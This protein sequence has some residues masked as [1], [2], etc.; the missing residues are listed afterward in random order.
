M[1]NKIEDRKKLYIP[2]RIKVEN[3][4]LKGFSG[5]SLKWFIVSGIIAS[6]ICFIIG[7]ITKELSYGILLWIFTLGVL[8][9]AFH[10]NELNMN[11]V[12]YFMVFFR[13]TG[14]QQ[15]YEYIFC[16]NLNN[17]EEKNGRRKQSK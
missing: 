5:R 13:F 15:K 16:D 7:L 9:V 10:E 1:E 6:V 8:A 2:A 11:M 12:D 3:E 4:P 17:L 14:E